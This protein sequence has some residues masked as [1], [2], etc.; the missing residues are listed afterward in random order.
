[1][2]AVVLSGGGHHGTQTATNHST[3]V[4]GGASRSAGG[5]PASAAAPPG[6]STPV[7]T[8]TSFYGL[9]A[10]HRY[11]E[12]W[13]LADPTFRSQLGGYG[14]FEAGQQADRSITFDEARVVS[15]S[16]GNAVVAVQTTSVRTDGTQHCVG[17]VELQH[18]SS[19]SGWLL[20]VIHINCA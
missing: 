1:V 9:A 12:A 5:A 14:S 10:S 2:L 13:A 7:S 4:A 8:V 17:T 11:A 16:A 6:A 19:P 20:H 3:R 15:Q 18:S